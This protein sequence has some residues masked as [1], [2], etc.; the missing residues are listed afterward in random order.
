[1]PVNKTKALKIRIDQL[2]RRVSEAEA[3]RDEWRR[4]ALETANVNSELLDALAQPAKVTHLP[5]A[6]G[7]PRIIIIEPQLEAS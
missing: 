1:M 2:E 6:Y 7:K 3:E 5:Q 4:I